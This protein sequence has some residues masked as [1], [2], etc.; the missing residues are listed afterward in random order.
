L[1]KKSY[2]D[3]K[4]AFFVRISKGGIELFKKH[5]KVVEHGCGC[6]SKRANQ[7]RAMPDNKMPMNPT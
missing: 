6:S 7:A 5:F 1:T 3:V 4:H 2:F